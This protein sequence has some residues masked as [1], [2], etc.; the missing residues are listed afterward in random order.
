MT[1]P[2]PSPRIS[3]NTAAIQ[4]LVP[5]CSCASS[6]IATAMIAVPAIGKNRYRPILE[7]SCPLTI[8][9]TSTPA[10]NGVSCS[11]ERVGLDPFVTWR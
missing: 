1:I 2:S 6:T 9:V 7:I 10:I 4:V 3:A 8:D 11:P 5:A